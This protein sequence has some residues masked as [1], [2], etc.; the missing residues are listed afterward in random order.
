[1]SNNAAAGKSSDD[2]DG[3]DH[4]SDAVVVKVAD[5]FATRKQRIIAEALCKKLQRSNG[6]I[7]GGTEQK[8]ERATTTERVERS[9]QKI[10]GRTISSDVPL[11]DRIKQYSDAVTTLK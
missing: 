8:I 1:M 9:L 11:K 7:F 6:P 5:V 4:P 2:L 3:K 10:L